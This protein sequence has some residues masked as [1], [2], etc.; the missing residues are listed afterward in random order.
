[1]W[2]LRFNG[3]D[4]IV[5]SGNY[6]CSSIRVAFIDENKNSHRKIALT[7][8]QITCPNN[9]A[10]RAS[11]KRVRP[12]EVNVLISVFEKSATEF[13]LKQELLKW[14]RTIQIMTFNARTLNR[15]GQLPELTASA[16]DH[17]IDIICIQEHRYTHSEDI[18]YHDTGNGWTLATASARKNSVN[19]SIWRAGLLIKSPMLVK[20]KNSSPL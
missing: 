16:I 11:Q 1:M 20:K 10:L 4:Q 3:Q 8:T 18:K 2:I 15:I 6:C 12:A 14:K 19:P 17:N 5:R 13:K 9:I 7:Y